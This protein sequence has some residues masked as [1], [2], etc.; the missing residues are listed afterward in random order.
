MSVVTD[1]ILLVSLT[2]E[3]PEDVFP[4]VDEVNN[5]LRENGQNAGLNHLNGHEGGHKAW[6]AD[7]FGAAFNFL[8]IEG[9]VQ[10]VAGAKWIAPDRVQLLIKGEEDEVWGLVNIVAPYK[11]RQSSSE[12]IAARRALGREKP[13]EPWE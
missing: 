6:Q 10:T 9:F 13:D 5:W 1:V 4:P 11:S 8:D 7:V 2:E 12:A 3:G